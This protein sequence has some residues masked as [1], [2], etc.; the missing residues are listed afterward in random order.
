[1]EQKLMLKDM[2]VEHQKSPL[3]ID[4]TEPRFG[5]KL[6]SSENNVLQTAYRITVSA[7]GVA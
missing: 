1:M 2:V 4:C 5:W 3:G 6:V 7:D